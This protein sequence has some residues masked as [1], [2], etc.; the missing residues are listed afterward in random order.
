MSICLIMQLS[1]G[2]VRTSDSYLGGVLNLKPEMGHP[3]A[4]FLYLFAVSHIC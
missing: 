1:S 3:L 4:T 2:N